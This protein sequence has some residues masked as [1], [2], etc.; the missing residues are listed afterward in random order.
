[1]GYLFACLGVIP[2]GL[3]ATL[4][5]KHIKSPISTILFNVLGHGGMRPTEFDEIAFFLGTLLVMIPYLLVTLRVERKVLIKRKA[6]L[7]TP[8]LPVTVRI[9]NNITYSLL[10][11]PVVIGTVQATIKLASNK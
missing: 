6:E 11:L 8:T 4:L 9:M 10:A 2:A 1:L 5:P 3:F 7:N